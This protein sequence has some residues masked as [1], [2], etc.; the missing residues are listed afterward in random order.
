MYKKMWNEER[1]VINGRKWGLCN[2]GINSSSILSSRGSVIH[3]S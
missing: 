2:S 3:C 1:N